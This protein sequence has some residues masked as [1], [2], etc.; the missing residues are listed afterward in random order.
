MRKKEICRT[1]GELSARLSF[2]A[3]LIILGLYWNKLFEALL[4]LIAILQFEI[5]YRQLWLAARRDKPIFC[6]YPSKT[7]NLVYLNVRNMGSTPAFSIMVS[8]LL[9]HGKPVPPM[10]W[11]NKWI[12]SQPIAFLEPSSEAT[13]AAI[14]KDFYEKLDEENY[15]IEVD[16]V[17][18][19]GNWEYFMIHFFEGEPWFMPEEEKP[20]GFLTKIGDYIYKLKYII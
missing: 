2:I 9:K 8:R 17:D 10:E 3:A 12:K 1:V 16:Y 14:D 13:L 19:D 5:A 6:V 18:K 20:P 4:T 15:A 11:D 7:E